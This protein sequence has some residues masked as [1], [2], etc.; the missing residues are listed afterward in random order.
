M[1]IARQG[2]N[3]CVVDFQTISYFFCEDLFYDCLLYCMLL[4][5]SFLIFYS[6]YATLEHNDETGKS[7]DSR[8]SMN[9]RYPNTEQI[10]QQKL[11]GTQVKVARKHKL[12]RGISKT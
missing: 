10:K 11:S 7:Q 5:T 8:P 12:E 6:I 3:P 4:D 9:F 1:G 2:S